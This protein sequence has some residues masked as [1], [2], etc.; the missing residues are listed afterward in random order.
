MPAT[1]P[2]SMAHFVLKASAGGECIPA[3]LVVH[4]RTPEVTMPDTA[5]ATHGGREPWRPNLLPLL[6]LMLA[7][8]ALTIYFLVDTY[9]LR[10]PSAKYTKDGTAFIL[11]L[12]EPL[13]TGLEIKAGG[14]RLLQTIA[15]VKQQSDDL[16]TEISARLTQDQTYQADLAAFMA[17][18]EDAEQMIDGLKREISALQR[19]QATASGASAEVQRVSNH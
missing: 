3:T 16:K 12:R 19:D 8:C 2:C 17:Q 1:F 9:L 7:T 6:T 18:L 14:A 5:I 13:D 4:Q 15:V 10:T 11:R